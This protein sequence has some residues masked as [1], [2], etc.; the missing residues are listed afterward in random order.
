MLLVSVV[1]VDCRLF[2]FHFPLLTFFFAPAT[3][4]HS[5]FRAGFALPVV[6]LVFGHVKI[7]F[8]YYK[9]PCTIRISWGLVE[10]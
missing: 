7:A 6:Q 4:C 1:A 8:A 3:L 2:W 10:D 5:L 9:G